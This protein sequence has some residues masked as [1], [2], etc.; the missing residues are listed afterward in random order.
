[1]K[2]DLTKMT[3]ETRNQRTMNLDE[4][5]SLEIVTAMNQEDRNVPLA[6]EKVLPEI[7]EL[8]SA[9]EEAFLKGARL[10][11]MGAGTSG[12]LGVLDASECPPT[13]GVPDTMVV[14]MIA[15]GDKALRYPI[16]GAEDD[17]ELG[18]TD[19]MERGLTKD[20]VVV[21]IAASG[22]TPYVI[23]GL[24]YAKSLGCTTAAVS[25]NKGSAIGQAA[26]IAIEAEVGPEVLTGSTRLKSGTAQKLILNMITTASMVRIGKVYQNLMVDVVQ[27]NEKLRQRAENIVIEATGV[28]RDEARRCID[29]ANGS[30]KLAITMILAECDV[31]TAEKLLE[32]AG[33]HVR[34]AV[35]IVGGGV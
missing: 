16:E 4:M 23:G 3:T 5:S 21:G 17:K 12:R 19:L 29:E 7:A 8:V 15:G 31:Q 35:K 34:E 1:M 30:C 14:G 9:V 27:S 33:G 22:R 32:Q 11:Y 18:K 26:D 25:C 28:Q 10:F 13:Y 2:M 6:I 24:E 20:D